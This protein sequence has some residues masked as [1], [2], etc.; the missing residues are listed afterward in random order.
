MN[1]L[2]TTEAITTGILP[3]KLNLC[4]KSQKLTFLISINSIDEHFILFLG[5][6]LLGLR[7]MI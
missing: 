6:C 1:F 7:A 3:Y 5:K 2:Q 4:L